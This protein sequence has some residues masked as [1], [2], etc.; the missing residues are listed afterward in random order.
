MD[1]SVLFERTSI[2]SDRIKNQDIELLS[3]LALKNGKIENIDYEIK[4]ISR[5]SHRRKNATANTPK[6]LRNALG[7]DIKGRISREQ[8]KYIFYS[9]LKPQPE[10]QEK[11]GFIIGLTSLSFT[12]P[13]DFL[14]Y[15][16]NIP[17]EFITYLN[18]VGFLGITIP[19]QLWLPR[20]NIGQLGIVW[21]NSK[22]DSDRLQL[23]MDIEN[24]SIKSIDN[25]QKLSGTGFKIQA[26]QTKG[27]ILFK[28]Q[29]WIY[30]F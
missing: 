12:E 5:L 29:K 8:N 20:G 9:N 21:D 25:S 17:L 24:F 26:S 22:N 7:F 2:L 15:G 13:S 30:N 4:A 28:K 23:N 3:W 18:L 1:L 10:D 16:E 14:L 11:D 27:N 6:L 19:D